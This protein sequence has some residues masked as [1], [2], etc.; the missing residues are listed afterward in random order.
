MSLGYNVILFLFYFDLWQK[1]GIIDKMTNKGVTKPL[2]QKNF[3]IFVCRNKSAYMQIKKAIPLIVALSLA[4]PMMGQTLIPI[5][6]TQQ[7]S[8]NGTWQVRMDNHAMVVDIRVPGNWNMQGLGMPIYPEGSTACV[9]SEERP[10]HVAEYS[11]TFDVPVAWKGQRAYL[12]MDGAENGYTLTV[13]GNVIGS[14]RSAFNRS[15]FDI[16]EAVSFDG[17]NRLTITV[18]QN[19]MKGWEFD[20]NDDWVFG[21]ISRDVTL[22][23][24]PM[25]HFQ[26]VTVKTTMGQD[27]ANVTVDALLSEAT[28]GKAYRV[29]GRLLDPTGR[30][31]AAFNEM[32]GRSVTMGLKEAMPWSAES[33]TLYTLQLE[34]QCNG[35]T[36]ERCEQRIGL[37]EISWKDGVFRINGQAVKLRG[38]N[39]HDE[40]PVNGRSI[41]EEEMLRDLH[42]MKAANINTIRASHYPPSPHFMDMCDSLGFYVICEVPFG[43]GDQ[44]LGK[45]DYAEVLRERAW[46]T[47]MR[48]KNRPSVV[49]WSVGNENPNTHNGFQTA[50]YVHQLDATR[51]YVFPQTHKP[52]NQLLNEMPDSTE[53]FSAHYPLASEYKGWSAKAHRPIMDT[54]YAHALGT[55]MGQMQ[56]LVDLWYKDEKLS[57]GCVWEWADQGLLRHD[58]RLTD[59]WAPTEYVWT[60]DSTYYD[61]QGILG[62]DGIVYPDRTPQTDYYQVRK[63]YSP[64]QILGLE[65]NGDEYAMKLVN[66]YAFTPLSTVTAHVSLMCNAQV[67]Q[68]TDVKLDGAPGDT[69]MLRLPTMKTW[70][71][72]DFYYYHIALKDATGHQFYEKSL[73]MNEVSHD[74]RLAWKAAYGKNVANKLSSERAISMVEHNLLVRLGKKQSLC[75]QADVE[76]SVGQ[77]HHLWGKDLLTV[78]NAKVR[79]VK[80]DTF[81]VS[82]VFRCDS[83]HYVDGTITLAQMPGGLLHIGYDLTAHGDGE[84]VEMGLTFR[85]EADADSVIYRWLGRGPFACYPGKDALSEFG[86]WCVPGADLYF[87]GNR[88]ETQ[89]AMLVDHDG[90]GLVLVP[91]SAQNICVER[92]RG[93]K[94]L[95]SQNAHVA[96]PFNKGVW[97]KGTVQTDGYRMKDGFVLGFTNNG[98]DPIEQRYFKIQDPSKQLHDFLDGFRSGHLHAPFRAVY[99]Q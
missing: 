80:G 40:S 91:D 20:T 61:M 15:M 65:R 24:V 94:V 25:V 98:H 60:N 38:V 13:N 12:M 74:K 73:R 85:T 9:F 42:L 33:P 21:G 86:A 97:A 77:K 84:A 96:C 29:L 93:G 87:P 92:D 26:D 70:S 1:Y 78:S 58:R 34:L 7:V 89:M 43:F 68:T 41:T 45:A 47:V 90:I 28:N 16:T 8:L 48:D 3:L 62:T 11:R 83:T 46:H 54:E 57:G 49:I 32:A 79:R 75:Q 37:R 17:D 39:H 18:P 52:F 5:D 99:D 67:L 22:C 63:V 95:V 6:P 50:R 30:E 27:G 64:V 2:I 82:G 71:Q 69:V 81:E 4:C 19:Q 14:F 55:D 59:R 35:K 36:V 44:H 51:P 72:E 23:A 53:M 88:G 10:A 66:R 76:G 31:V 56:E